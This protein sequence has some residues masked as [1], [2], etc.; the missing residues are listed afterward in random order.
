[1]VDFRMELHTPHTLLLIG[2]SGVLH[3]G[4]R[5]RNMIAIGN[6]RDGVAM[7]HPH[8]RT[9][10]KAFKHSALRIDVFEIGSSVF[11]SASLFHTTALAEGDE[12]RTITDTQ[13]GIAT[14]NLGEVDTESLFVVY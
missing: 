5:S 11:A 2:K 9:F 13:Y 8:L 12:L 14:D 10:V 3:V 6:G 4:C 1:M 7:T